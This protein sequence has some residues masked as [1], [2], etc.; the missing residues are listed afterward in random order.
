MITAEQI[1]AARAL[2]RLE[3]EELARRSGVSVTTI[4][5][6]EAHGGEGVVAPATVGTVVQVLREAGVEFLHEGVSLKAKPAGDEALLARLRGIAE[7]AAA[8]ASGR[9][10]LT[11]AD[12]YGDDGLPR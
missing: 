9:P 5:R 2:L 3:Q 1:K 12:L 8:E 4:R 11:D 7:R 6:L 10:W